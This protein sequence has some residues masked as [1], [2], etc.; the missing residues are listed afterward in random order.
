MHFA[1]FRSTCCYQKF[2]G[3]HGGFGKGE[4][5]ARGRAETSSIAPIIQYTQFEFSICCSFPRAE[6]CKLL[7]TCAFYCTCAVSTQQEYG[8]PET[9]Q[10]YLLFSNLQVFPIMHCW[11]I[12]C[13]VV[14]DPI[15]VKKPSLQIVSFLKQFVSLTKSNTYKCVPARLSIHHTKGSRAHISLQKT[16][17]MSVKSFDPALNLRSR[18][19]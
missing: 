9:K 16:G 7:S 15:L 10:I 2:I 1:R 14:T 11:R 4:E 18:R 19:L 13:Q 17:K 3:C 12:L 8:L 5:G 6:G